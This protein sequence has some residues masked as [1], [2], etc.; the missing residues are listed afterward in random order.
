MIHQLISFLIG[1][2]T[3]LSLEIDDSSFPLNE[4]IASHIDLKKTLG[5]PLRDV[6]EEELKHV[7]IIDTG[8][9]LKHDHLQK[10]FIHG[11]NAVTKKSDVEISFDHKGV[12]A[13]TCFARNHGTHMASIIS[14]VIGDDEDGQRIK[15]VPVK[16]G[17]QPLSDLNLHINALNFIAGR[18]DI[19]VVSISINYPLIFHAEPDTFPLFKEALQGVINSGKLLV[20]SALNN[21]K[22][23]IKESPFVQFVLSPEAKGRIIVVGATQL[24]DDGEEVIATFSNKAGAVSP[25]FITAPGSNLVCATYLFKD[26]LEHGISNGVEIASGSSHATAV[27]AG[28]L[29]SLINHFP[30][31]PIDEIRDIL[32]TSALKTFKNGARRDIHLYGNGLLSLDKAW[33]LAAT[34]VDPRR[35]DLLDDSDKEEIKANEELSKAGLGSPLSKGNDLSTPWGNFINVETTSKKIHTYWRG[36]KSNISKKTRTTSDAS[37]IV[38]YIPESTTPKKVLHKTLIT[39]PACGIY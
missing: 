28:A 22:F 27:V 3:C 32:F 13:E 8:F 23:F 15:I 18:S 16:V 21:K 36:L 30:M 26:K 5:R 35:L 7:A 10:R 31:I 19:A 33:F 4:R 34:K 24:N 25:Q 20:L 9:Y 17:L 1:C 12:D 6:E 14:Q 37:Q 11:F 2:T 38:I 29:I 39:A